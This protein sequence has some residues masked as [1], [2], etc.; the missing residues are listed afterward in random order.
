VTPEE[1]LEERHFS[2]Y[3]FFVEIFPDRLHFETFGFVVLRGAFD[4]GALAREVDASMRE[5][6]LATSAAEVGAARQTIRFSYVPMM[7]AKTPASL[8]LLAQLEAVAADLLGGPV[9]PT[10][11][12]G[13][14]YSGDTPW[15]AD[16]D[17]EVA[18]LGCAAYLEPLEAESGALRV[19]PGSHRPGFGDAIRAAGAVGLAA[20]ALPSHVVSTEPGDVIAFDE[21]LFHASAGGAVRRQWRVDYVRE[22]ED[23]ESRA[24]VKAYFARIFPPDWDGGYDVDQYPSYDADW[25]ASRR[26]AAVMLGELGVYELAAIQEAFSRKRRCSSRS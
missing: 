11:A 26:R 2:C 14:R 20:D 8:A 22:P 16:S 3:A 9:L 13:V 19:L 10:R 23:G 25:R 4:P 7:T 6:A 18:S 24:R 5:L 21:H 1:T 15:H 17:A 12:K